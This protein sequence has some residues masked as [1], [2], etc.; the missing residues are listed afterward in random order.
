MGRINAWWAAWYLAQD[1]L[2]GGGIGALRIASD[3]D[4]VCAESQCLP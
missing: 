3:H 2:L 1:N 4:K